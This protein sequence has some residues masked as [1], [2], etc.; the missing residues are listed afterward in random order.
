[1]TGPSRRRTLLWIALAVAGLAVAVGGS[2]AASRLAEPKVGL[3]SEPL[4]GIEQ[5]A[6]SQHNAGGAP[7]PSVTTAPTT[8]TA[9]VTVPAGPAQAP[10]PS[11]SHDDGSSEHEHD[12]DHEDDHDD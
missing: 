10:A 8:P 7:R 1:M 2:Y 5:L 12:D 3:S 11:A 9:T 6:P 4:S